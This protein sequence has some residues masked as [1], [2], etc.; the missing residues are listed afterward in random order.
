MKQ[1]VFIL[2]LSLIFSGC[3]LSVSSKP[4]NAAD[5]YAHMV[6]Y[7]V[8]SDFETVGDQFKEAIID[9]GMVINNVSHISNMLERTRVDV[10]AGKQIYLHAEAFEFCSSVISRNTMEADPHNIVFCPYVV[11][12]YELKKNPGKI[13]VAY[14]KPTR[15]GSDVTSTVMKEVERL[16]DEL[17]RQAIE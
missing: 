16:L 11:A 17:A 13:H 14:R 1:F 7:T 5:P 6:R 10:G 2:G 3:A 4:D 8:S 15:S 12:I 9:K